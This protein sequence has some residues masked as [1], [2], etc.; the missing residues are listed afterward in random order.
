[1]T[2]YGRLVLYGALMLLLAAPAMADWHPGDGHKMHYPQL[3]DRSGW[4]VEL[5][6]HFLADDWECSE[7]G[8][9]TDIHFWFSWYGDD[10]GELT[11]V[12]VS[13]WDDAGGVPGNMLWGQLFENVPYVPYGQ[14]PQGWYAPEGPA[15]EP[16]N[17]FEYF[18][19]NLQDIDEP[20]YQEAG[21]RYWLMIMV[22]WP[23]GI[24]APPGWKTSQDHFGA[25]PVWMNWYAPPE[26][27]VLTEPT[28]EPLSLAF[29]ITGGEPHTYK[30]EQLPDLDVTGIDVDATWGDEYLLADDYLCTQT[31]PITKISIWGS[32][33]SDYYGID[34]SEISFTLSIHDDIP[35]GPDGWS[36]P[37]E[38]LWWFEFQ[39][40]M[41]DVDVYASEIEEGWLWP[42]DEYAPDADW[43]CW[44]Y[45]FPIDSLW[46]FCQQGTEDEPIVYWLDLQAT[47]RDPNAKFGWKTSVD[48]WNDD[49]V[50][51][52]GEEPYAGIDWQELRYPFG[53]PWY[54]ESIDLAFRID[55][56][57]EPSAAP[58]QQEL[59]DGFG[60]Q[61]TSPNPFREEAMISFDV[62][63]EGGDVT[64]EI[65]D[66][67][68]RC[69]STLVDGFQTGGRHN[70]LWQGV[71]ETGSAVRSGLYM[72]RLQAPGFEQSVKLVIMP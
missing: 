42:P 66:L 5:F 65:F 33:L 48:H 41:F 45:T 56:V 25:P 50:W 62:P 12:D 46:A 61:I 15:W 71:D 68:G 52:W 36:I 2:R 47:P 28:G 19:V 11:I 6:R 49:A 55:G 30:W 21:T 24:Q 27:V 31:G 37:G 67:E 64:L 72:C 54:T 4:D 59:P 70:V 20:F 14:G 23:T 69:V 38:L 8:P 22:D 58:E 60:L 26:W 10:L 57:A 3:P 17:H 29:V 9:V 34:P 44:R 16:N 7:S 13:I 43:T 35:V 53:H 1:M 40:G 63:A 18:Q 32:W 39:P 51:V